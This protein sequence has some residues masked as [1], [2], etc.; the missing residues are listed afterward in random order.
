MAQTRWRL[1]RARRLEAA[2]IEDRVAHRGSRD[3]DAMMSGALR[4]DTASTFTTLQRYAAA[5]ERNAFRA[6]DQIL[7]LRK[8]AA[9]AARDAARQS[10]QRRLLAAG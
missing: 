6:V 2:V 4:N 7:A 5:I 1:A 8:L 3:A 10:E 9:Q